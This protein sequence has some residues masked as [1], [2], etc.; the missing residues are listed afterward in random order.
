MKTRTTLTGTLLVVAAVTAATA[1]AT[2]LAVV[3]ATPADGSSG[4]AEQLPQQ[5]GDETTTAEQQQGN[6]TTVENLEIRELRLVNVTVPTAS[7]DRIV[8]PNHTLTDVSTNG[9]VVDGTLR[10]VTLENVTVRNESLA[11]AL[12]VSEGGENAS[13]GDVTLE[14]R[15]IERAV[16]GSVGVDNVSDVTVRNTTSETSYA[17]V[18]TAVPDIEVGT[19]IVQNASNVTLTVIGVETAPETGPAPETEADPAL[20]TETEPGTETEPATETENGTA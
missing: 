19:A 15:T 9:A 8:T 16:L 11:T 20:E 12:G 6:E 5:Q 1:L 17:R 13:V 10:N 3:G 4:H 18:E 2:P 14:N 7:A